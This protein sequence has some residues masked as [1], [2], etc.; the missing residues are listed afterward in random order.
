MQERASETYLGEHDISE[1]C[2]GADEHEQHEV[3]QKDG[4]CSYLERQAVVVVRKVVEEGR[5]HARAHDHSMPRPSKVP[6]VVIVSTIPI[7]SGWRPLVTL[8][9]CIDDT[10]EPYT[11]AVFARHQDV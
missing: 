9:D 6:I 5:D 11:L 10:D 8:L 4:E 2:A 1:Y 7:M 3:Q